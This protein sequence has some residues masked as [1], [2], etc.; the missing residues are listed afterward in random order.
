[1]T[2]RLRLTLAYIGLLVPALVAFSVVVYFIASKRLYNALDDS[3]QSRIDAVETQ[4]P[5]DHRLT[6]SDITFSNIASI[7]GP[8]TGY[9]FRILDLNG[10]VLYASLAARGRDIPDV[11]AFQDGSRF[12]TKETGNQNLRISYEP[13]LSPSGETLGY[14]ES[15]T[16]LKQTDR[17]LNELI[18]VFVIGGIL[19]VLATGVPAYILAGRALSPVRQV[20]ALASEVERTAD[21]TKRLP[22]GAPKGDVAELVR[23]FNAMIE[24]VERMLVSQRDFLAESS[25]ELRRPLAVLRTYI[26]LLQEPDLPEGE[27]HACIEDMRF[28][29]EA[30]ARLISDLLLLSR[31]G[32]QAM[33]R[34]E[35]DVSGICER[36][37]ARLREQDATHRIVAKTDRGVKVVG[38]SE[39]IEQMIRNLLENASQNTPANGEI[40][41]SLSNGS[42]FAR[43]EVKDSGRGIPWDEQAHVFD[44]FFRGRDARSVRADGVGLGLAIVKHVAES[45]GGSV[46]FVS[47]PGSGTSFTVKLPAEVPAK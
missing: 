22:P 38:D 13:V 9:S 14:I 27:R 10:R 35:V 24:R 4:L 8:S 17:A 43:I 37:V 16:S 41:V 31:E 7:E 2:L 5:H 6:S 30:M 42:G 18:G 29:A 39:K 1:V 44:R 45:H 12:L 28:E 46:D 26:D 23:T 19:V 25:H 33:R 32:E 40:D 34:G 11:S 15:A 36:L 47:V 20:S 3:L 21:F